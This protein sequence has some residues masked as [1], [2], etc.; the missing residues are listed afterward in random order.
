MSQASTSSGTTQSP[1]PAPGAGS[2][3]A[4]GSTMFAGVLLLVDGILGILNGIGGIASGDVYA[5]IGRYVFEWNLT[6]WGWIHLIIGVIAAVTGVGI[7]K[8][9]GWARPVGV[10][11]AGLIIIV[12]FLWLPYLPL[13]ALIN[14][15]IGVFVIW[16]LCKG[17]RPSP[18][19]RPEV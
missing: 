8:N 2:A 16:A 12:N 5:V 11:M 15:A 10:A 4:A 17:D 18:S 9:A 19:S 7:L 13:W 6:A 1:A 14:I 3:W